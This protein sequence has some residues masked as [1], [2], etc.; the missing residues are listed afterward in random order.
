MTR[1]PETPQFLLRA[2]KEKRAEQAFIFYQGRRCML[3]LKENL[4]NQFE[5][6]KSTY[7]NQKSA[8][9][10]VTYQDFC[11]YLLEMIYV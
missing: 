5:Q 6:L 2:G 10:K 9:K 8:G 7:G 3:T 11:K 4:R 1:Y